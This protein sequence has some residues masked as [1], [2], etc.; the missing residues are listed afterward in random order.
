MRVSRRDGHGCNCDPHP[1][2]AKTLIP[3]TYDVTPHSQFTS[4]NNASCVVN[5]ARNSLPEA[6]KSGSE[7]RVQS[8]S[9]AT[10]R[11]SNT[12]AHPQLQVISTYIFSGM[13]K[14]VD[15][16][17]EPVRKEILTFHVHPVSV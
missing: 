16:V 8:I 1:G 13:L 3:P 11:C 10:F 14:D 9:M 7:H 17:F 5:D 12:C 2:H 15:C 6:G 4:I